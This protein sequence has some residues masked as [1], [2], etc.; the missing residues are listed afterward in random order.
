MESLAFL[1]IILIF[2]L[3]FSYVLCDRDMMAPDV[4]YIAGFGYVGLSI[5]ILLSQRHQLNQRLC[6]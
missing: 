6:R 2:L 3:M 5:A 4:L 1:L